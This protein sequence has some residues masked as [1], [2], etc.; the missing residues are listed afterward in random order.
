VDGKIAFATT[1]PGDSESNQTEAASLGQ[2]N[3]EGR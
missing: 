3:S 2:V 1:A